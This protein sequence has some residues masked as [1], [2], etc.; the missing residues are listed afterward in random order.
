MAKIFG[1]KDASE[2]GIRLAKIL[3]VLLPSFAASFMISTTF[4]M[5]FIAESLGGGDFIAGLGL[6]GFLV[7]VQLVVQTVFDYP[8]GAIGD[9]L[10]HRFVIASALLCYGFAFWL[11]ANI[12][13]QT[14]FPIFILIYAMVGF[15]NSQESGAFQAWFDNNYRV[16]VPQDTDRKQYGVF[17]GRVG[18]MFE[19]VTTLVLLPGS[20]LALLYG[21]PW[22]FQVQ[23]IACVI[24]AILV[25]RFLK[26]IPSPEEEQ[27]ERPDLKDYGRLLKDGFKFLFS[28]RF[29]TLTILGE[30]IIWASGIVWWQLILFPLYFS[31]L[32]TDVAVSSFRTLIFAPLAGIQERSGVW[33]KHFDPKK[34]IPRFRILQF[35]G[36]VFYVLLALV[37]FVFPAPPINSPLVQLTIPIL[38]V[39]IIEMPISSI[40]PMGL[41]FAV[42]VTC[43]LFSA[44]A[45][46][47]T[48]RVMIDVIP[49]R[50]R[51]CIYSLRPTITMILAIPLIIFF[52]WWIPIGGFSTT[53]LLISPI[54]LIGAFLVYRGYKLPIPVAAD[55]EASN[56]NPEEK[57]T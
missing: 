31:Y 32:L 9:W 42:F 7:V 22:V 37:L 14:P 1:L 5:I 13:P 54:G 10:G 30:V 46:I 18:M 16:A 20:W 21:R 3:I 55:F 44:F 33:S 51:N 56:T 27:K 8:T 29:I 40:I 11:T 38:N 28:T 19:L 23:T 47:L 6:V 52:G 50:I 26:D 2:S 12:T 53:F 43:E 4:W 39:P 25:V 48:Q 24:L 45:N 57:T 15:G 17:M 41:L 35:C 49:N 36:F 34:W